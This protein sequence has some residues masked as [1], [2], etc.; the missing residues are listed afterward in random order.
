MR[1]NSFDDAA[2]GSTLTRRVSILNGVTPAGMQQAMATPGS[3]VSNV[4]LLQQRGGDAA[5]A[6]IPQD[7]SSRCSS[8]DYDDLCRFH[9]LPFELTANI[10]HQGLHPLPSLRILFLDNPQRTVHIVLFHS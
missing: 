6:Q 4:S 1:R 2:L 5:Q 8:A 9:A 3:A 7:A 10:L